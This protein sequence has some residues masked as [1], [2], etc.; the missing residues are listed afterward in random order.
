MGI[1]M[2]SMSRRLLTQHFPPWPQIVELR[3]PSWHPS[4]TRFA[5]PPKLGLPLLLTRIGE[6]HAA[7]GCQMPM[8]P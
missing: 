8:H 7:Y 4:F 2:I 1:T 5:N 3:D 6:A